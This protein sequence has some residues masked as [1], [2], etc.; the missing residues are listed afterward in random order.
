M[1]PASEHCVNLD[2]VL[3][4][5]AV[6]QANIHTPSQVRSRTLNFQ[7]LF[8]DLT[9]LDCVDNNTPSGKFYWYTKTDSWYT[10]AVHKLNESI[11]IAC[12]F[13]V[14]PAS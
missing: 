13:L 5:T 14:L 3:R 10:K 6:K 7:V 9:Q 4:T 11:F 2:Y 8:P 1:R 12:I